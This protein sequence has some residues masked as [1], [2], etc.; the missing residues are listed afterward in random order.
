MSR[1]IDQPAVPAIGRDMNELRAI[2]VRKSAQEPACK[3]LAVIEKA[4]EGDGAGARSIVEEDGDGAVVLEA[5]EIW[6]SRVDCGT[7]RFGP[8]GIL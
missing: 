5:N 3:G 6:L 2:R 7:W 8:S 1:F 4:F